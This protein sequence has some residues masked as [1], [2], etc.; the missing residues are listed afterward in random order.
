MAYRVDKQCQ[1][2]NNWDKRNQKTSSRLACWCRE[3]RSYKEPNEG[4]NCRYASSAP[5]YE[6]KGYYITTAALDVCDYKEDCEILQLIKY[7]RYD[8]MEQNPEN[9]KL[10]K[11]Y[12]IVGPIIA[13][14][15]KEENNNVEICLNLIQHYIMPTA[16]YVKSGFYD[17]AIEVYKSMVDYLKIKYSVLPES[18][19]LECNN[20]S[21]I[22][23]KETGFVRVQKNAVN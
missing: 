15:L 8:Y 17:K 14:H 10:L 3:V 12:D 9:L 21:E 11:E 7:L 18:I 20:L 4:R 1:Y 19:E 23:K 16:I 22:N 6:F 5:G 2:C 13:E